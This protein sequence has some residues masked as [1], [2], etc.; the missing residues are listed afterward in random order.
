MSL[1]SFLGA[2]LFACILIPLLLSA[3]DTGIEFKAYDKAKGIHVDPKQH[4]Q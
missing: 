2:F 3:R 4:N 1:E